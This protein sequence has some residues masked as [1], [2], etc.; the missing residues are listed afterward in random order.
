MFAGRFVNTMGVAARNVQLQLV[1]PPGF[2]VVHFS[3][4]GYSE[5]PMEID[6]QHI[7]PNDAMVFY[8]TLH[9]CAPDALY[10]E[11]PISVG[12]RYQDAISFEA[13]EIWLDTTWGELQARDTSLLRKGA[14]VY[15]Y[16]E[17]L[18]TVIL[19]D[20]PVR[21]EVALSEAMDTVEVAEAVNPGDADLEEIRLV[22]QAL[23]A[24]PAMAD[25]STTDRV[26]RM[27][28]RSPVVTAIEENRK[29]AALEG[30]TPAR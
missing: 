21:R 27:L 8:N 11:T 19:T 17:A 25:A 6:P 23:G 20:N 9:T 30:A 29:R 5:D 2:E 18:K 13:Q 24:Q 12:V 15:G 14:A 16:A 10:D 1:L 7:A 3:G 22:L 4:E 28:R 26:A